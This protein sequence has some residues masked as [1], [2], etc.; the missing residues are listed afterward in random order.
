MNFDLASNLFLLQTGKERIGDGNLTK[1][2]WQA[3]REKPGWL[4]FKKKAQKETGRCSG[5]TRPA[6][7]DKGCVGGCPGMATCAA[8]NR[9][10]SMELLACA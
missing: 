6:G 10:D 1:L 4:F 7:L 5:E 8:Y 3:M 9:N 2:A